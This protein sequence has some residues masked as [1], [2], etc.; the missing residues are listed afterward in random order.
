MSLGSDYLNKAISKYN[1]DDP[2]DCVELFENKIASFC[3]SKYAISTDCCTHA[4]FLCLRY[5]NKTN[6]KISLPFN[7]YISLPSV[8]NMAGYSFKFVDHKWQ[9]S[10]LLDPLNIIDSATCLKKNMYKDGTLTCL[11]FHFRKILPI[12]RGGMILTN[13]ENEYK[14]LTSKRYDGRNMR[15]KYDEDIFKNSGYHMY[16]TPEQSAYG[17]HL[18]DNEQ[19]NQIELPNYKGYKSLE[20]FDYLFE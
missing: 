7:T 18:F 4:I 13:S 2:W 6:T 14:W 1:L 3:G 8:I 15:V 11:S 16:M 19:F 12:G 5:V 17:I 9:D 20:K 10:Y